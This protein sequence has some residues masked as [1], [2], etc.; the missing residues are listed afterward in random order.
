[1]PPVNQRVRENIQ[2]I[3]DQFRN[4]DVTLRDLARE[5]KAAR[6]TIRDALCKAIGKDAY[7][8]LARKRSNTKLRTDIREALPDIIARLKTTDAT[9]NEIAGEY[10]VSHG[11]I[12]RAVRSELSAPEYKRLRK[13]NKH[14][15][16][17]QKGSIPWHAGKKGVHF[18]PRTEYLAGAIRGAAARRFKPIGTILIRKGGIKPGRGVP[19]R[20]QSYRVIK[21]SGEG[22]RNQRW[23]RYARYLWEQDH[24][25]VPEGFN[26]GHADGDSIN[27]D[28][29]N[30]ILETTAQRNSRLFRQFPK[31]LRKM[32]ANGVRGTKRRSAEMRQMKES[33]GKV[34][35]RYECANCEADYFGEEPERCPKCGCTS[36]NEYRERANGKGFISADERD[37]ADAFDNVRAPHP[38]DEK[39]FLLMEDESGPIEL[40][41]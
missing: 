28:K 5:H 20:E 27:D 9:M 25:P 26:V 30:L 18:S 4:T 22:P 23:I 21:V 29:A 12:S 1:M 32:V 14:G 39:E 38:E 40:C 19:V 11:V 31:R 36:F 2:T 41:E 24:G 34:M 37:Q 16:L 13:G 3:V 35:L 15:G 6:G 8:D 7:E 10:G 17:I 33:L